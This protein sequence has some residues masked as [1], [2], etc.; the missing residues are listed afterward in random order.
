MLET[1]YHAV[2]Q[3][4]YNHGG[5]VDCKHN[6]RINCVSGA[7]CNKCGWNPAVTE[8]RKERLKTFYTD[9]YKFI[10]LKRKDDTGE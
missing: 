3:N 5:F 2:Y 1:K 8:K 6:R 10:K 9:Y 4:A 7:D